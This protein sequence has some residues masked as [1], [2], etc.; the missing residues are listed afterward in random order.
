MAEHKP[1]EVMSGRPTPPMVAAAARGDHAAVASLLAGGR[2]S[3]AVDQS[4]DN[5]RTPLYISSREGHEAVVEVLLSAGAAVDKPR[6]TG[7]TPLYAASFGGHIAVVR[8]LLAA[9]AEPSSQSAHGITPLH[10]ASHNG[11]KEV[12]TALLAA[13]AAVNHPHPDRA[14]VL[15]F[16]AQQGHS[17]VVSALLEAG[18]KVNQCCRGF[19]ALHIAIHIG[20]AEVAKVLCSH[21]A[22]RTVLEPH[23]GDTLQAIAL[24][25]GHTQLA[26]WLIETAEWN[27]ALHYIEL[28]PPARVRSLLRSGSD[29]FASNGRGGPTP[30]SLA[31]RMAETGRAP[32]GSTARL[33]LLAAGRWS[34]VSHELFPEPARWRAVELMRLGWL[35]SREARFCGEEQALVDIWRSCV[36]PLAVTR[37]EA[38]AKPSGSHDSVAKARSRR[39]EGAL[40]HRAAVSS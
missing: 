28:V 32:K 31:G 24:R 10:V 18:A 39:W 7:M 3:S 9:R 29:P 12:M 35:L 36:L 33:L 21:G 26:R 14:A 11:H 27:S 40:R 8:R 2:R 6:D 38:G 22:D 16:A 15:H 30:V 37:N 34:P 25:K 17:D 4:D 5:D 20:H 1:R 13:G 19:T 23:T